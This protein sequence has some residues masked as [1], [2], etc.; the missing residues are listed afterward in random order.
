MTIWAGG[1]PQLLPVETLVAHV[2]IPLESLA[3]P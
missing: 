1:H 3:D 2:N